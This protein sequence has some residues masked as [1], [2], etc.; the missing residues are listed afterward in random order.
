MLSARLGQ[1]NDKYR[2]NVRR[3]WKG[4]QYQTAELASRLAGSSDVFNY[5]NRDIWSSINFI[6]AH[7]GFS[8]HDVV[9]FNGKHNLSNGENN[10]DGTD[11]NWSWNSG[12]EGETDNPVILENRRQRMKAMI[13]TLLLSFGTPMIL[14]GDEFA[15]SQFGNNNPYCQDN[16]LTWIAWDAISKEDKEQVKFVR[17]VI[18]L[19]KNCAYSTAAISSS[20]K[21]SKRI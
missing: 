13:S 2:D 15:H 20:A 3:F 16:V 17:R 6:T 1:W 4:D 18:G 11:S 21:L 14:A 10:R 19:R 7:D 9:S 12:A 8:L 5:M